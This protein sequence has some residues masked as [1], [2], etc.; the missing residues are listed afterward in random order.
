[1][2]IKESAQKTVSISLYPIL[3]LFAVFFPIILWRL[4]T[5]LVGSTYKKYEQ[6]FELFGFCA[7]V[8]LIVFAYVELKKRYGQPFNNL[9]PVILPILV[10]FNY[11]SII[12]EY[13][14]YTYKIYDYQCYEAAAKAVL[15]GI[16]PYTNLGYIYTYPPL[17]A[18]VLAWL[19][20]LIDRNI[21]IIHLADQS[22]EQIWGLVF[23]FYQCGQFLLIGLAYFLGYRFA[24]NIGLESVPASFLLAAILLFNNPLLRTLRHGQI[25]LWLL[26]LFLLAVLL[27]QRYPLISGFLIAVGGHIKLYPL[28]LLMPWGIAKQWK[29]VLGTIA[30]FFI[31]LLIQTN[32]GTNWSLWEQFLGFF[33]SGS[34]NSLTIASPYVPDLLRNN[35]LHSVIFNFSKGI[36]K[37]L[38]IQIGFANV[39]F[40]LAT[41]AVIVWF[42][43]RF[44]K[45]EQAYYALAKTAEIP[46]S[47]R[48]ENTFRLYGHSVDALSLGLLISPSVWEHHYVLAIPIA[49]WAIAT[50]GYEKPWTVGISTFLMFC[51]PTFDVFPF[52]Y[53]RILGLLV[54]LYIASPHS[55]PDRISRPQLRKQATSVI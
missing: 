25:N 26:D 17:T 43:F 19:Y 50:R 16:T 32:G 24:K 9:L 5:S 39:V 22:P 13:S 33:G 34:S 37:I 45:R 46:T 31:I 7:S 8:S 49:V 12:S 1:M 4:N 18:Q 28:I 15:A 55:I 3:G 23:Y 54:L 35:S 11:L 40:L 47:D 21:S 51:L 14:G 27:L 53:H 29:A 20:Q 42:G 38:G 52:S 30:S 41:L 6:L 2:N 48:R 10:C 44:I 36:G